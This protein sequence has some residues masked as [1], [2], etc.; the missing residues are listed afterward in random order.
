[1]LTRLGHR[2][3]VSGHYQ[4]R[5]IDPARSDEHAANEILVTRHVDDSYDADAIQLEWRETEVDR[6]SAFLLFGQSV[7]VDTG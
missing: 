3:L 1:M 6:N 5:D 2:S 4:E 7:R